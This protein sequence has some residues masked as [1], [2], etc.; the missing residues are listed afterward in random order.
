M[1]QL[2]PSSISVKEKKT[3]QGGKTATLTL[4]NQAERTV[5]FLAFLEPPSSLNLDGFCIPHFQEPALLHQAHVFHPS[6][7]ILSDLQQQ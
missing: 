2:H 3:I 5:H 1:Y 7:L 6:M 4:F